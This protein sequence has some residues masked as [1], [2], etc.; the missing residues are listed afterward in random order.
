ML[1]DEAGRAKKLFVHRLVAIA[2]VG[3]APFE[4]AMVLHHDDDPT[5]NR[6]ANLYWGDRGQNARDARLNRKRAEFSQQGAQPGELNHAAVLTAHDVQTV[7]EYL[8]LGL[9]GSC[10]ARLFN[11]RK[12]TIYNI[13]KGRT[14]REL[15]DEM[16]LL[17]IDL[18]IVSPEWAYVAQTHAS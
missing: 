14:W 7:R 15:P 13:A 5:H 8:R 16:P 1:T 3:S 18:N 10:I 9:C 17:V 12:E 6:P 4:G 11:V 2:F